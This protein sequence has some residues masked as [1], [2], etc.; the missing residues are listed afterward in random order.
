VATT[1]D[2]AI[3]FFSWL[4]TDP[5]LPGIEDNSR[6]DIWFRDYI[7]SL[8][9]HGEAAEN[10]T[11]LSEAWWQAYFGCMSHYVFTEM[12][13]NTYTCTIPFVYEELNPVN[14][15]DPVQFYYIP[16]FVK[17][18]VLT[19]LE[20]SPEASAA[21]VS[22]NFPNPFSSISFVTVNLSQKSNLVM[23]IYDITGQ[24]VQSNDY[25]ILGTGGHKIEIDAAELSPGVYFYSVHANNLKITRKMIVQ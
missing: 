13:E 25:G 23:E 9:A 17:T 5:T 24:L 8:D 21:T 12:S 4:D 6:P 11:E 10:V 3:V 20:E 18:Y 7:P 1:P 16:D 22:Q 14:D 2:G 15:L 19:G